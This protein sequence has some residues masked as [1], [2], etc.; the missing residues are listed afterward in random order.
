MAAFGSLVPRVLLS[1]FL[2]L[3]HKLSVI[4]VFVV[5]EKLLFYFILNDWGRIFKCL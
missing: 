5:F 3:E 1:G 4:G 2:E